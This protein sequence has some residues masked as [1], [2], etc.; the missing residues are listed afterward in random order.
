MIYFTSDME[1]LFGKIHKKKE[2]GGTKERASS[3]LVLETRG[4]RFWMDET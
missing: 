3:L 4:R 2:L 1:D